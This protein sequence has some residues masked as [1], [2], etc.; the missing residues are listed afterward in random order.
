MEDQSLTSREKD[1]YLSNRGLQRRYSVGRTSLHNWMKDP[2][3]PKPYALSKNSF[4]WRLSELED[5]E[6]KCRRG[7]A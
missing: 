5:W 6:E 2:A 3:F 4:R 7:T 1:T